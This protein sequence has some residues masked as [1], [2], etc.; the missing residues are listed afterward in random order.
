MLVGP[1]FTFETS[2]LN[3][4]ISGIP[5]VKQLPASH[6]QSS[7]DPEPSVRLPIGPFC[8]SLVSSLPFL[9]EGLFAAP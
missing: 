1:G 6:P 2:P 5:N 8:S 3:P 4:H 9:S 7:R